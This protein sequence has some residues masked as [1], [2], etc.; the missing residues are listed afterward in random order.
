MSN[1]T[2]ERL[3]RLVDA[4]NKLGDEIKVAQQ[5]NIKPSS[6]ERMLRK[7]KERGI[8]SG[9]E[10]KEKTVKLPRV[11]VFDVENAPSFAAVWRMWK[12]N[13]NNEQITEEWYMLSWSAKWLMEPEVYSDVLTSDEAKEGKDKRIMQSLWEFVD[14]ADILVGHNINQFDILK[15]NTRFI[16]NGIKPPSSYQ[17]IDTLVAARKNLSFTS[18]KLDYLCAQFGVTRKA[19]NGGMARW[20]GC[21]QGDPVCLKDMEKYNRQDI[22]ATEELYLAMRPYIKNH[23]NIGLYLDSDQDTC[24]KCG[25]PNIEWLY[26]EV[27]DPKYYYT[28]TNRYHIYRC[29]EET[30]Q[31]IGRSRYSAMTKE[32]RKNITSPVAR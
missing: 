5:Q 23:P 15:M 8:V 20:I 25:S 32:Q 10:V 27:G 21:T 19:D 12:Q 1:S 14:H 7:A 6:V 22:I 3:Q 31:S 9:G 13:I 11:L 28:N 30:C 18:N 29:K 4:Y 26:D 24:Y 17:T 16:V 2:D